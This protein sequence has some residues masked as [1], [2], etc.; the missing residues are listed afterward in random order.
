MNCRLGMAFL[1]T[2]VFKKD[3][4]EAEENKIMGFIANLQNNHVINNNQWNHN[5]IQN[6]RLK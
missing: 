2:L 1:G 4:F 6:N 3:Q 5:K